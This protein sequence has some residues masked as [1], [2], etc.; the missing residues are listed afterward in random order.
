MIERGLVIDT[1]LDARTNKPRSTVKRS[2]ACVKIRVMVLS[3]E[4][5][6]AD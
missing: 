1:E 3:A 4:L 6:E 2:V 5:F